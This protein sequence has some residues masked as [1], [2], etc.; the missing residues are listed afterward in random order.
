MG[1][2]GVVGDEIDGNTRQS[3]S[4]YEPQQ[5]IRSFTWVIPI[6]G[7]VT[8]LSPK[9]LVT[10]ISQSVGLATLVTQSELTR[11]PGMGLRLRPAI[12]IAPITT[13]TSIP[14]KQAKLLA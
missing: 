5:P 1:D 13:S 2:V 9:T 11:I 6:T 14:T 10:P 3:D 8:L 12:I 7:L 4:V